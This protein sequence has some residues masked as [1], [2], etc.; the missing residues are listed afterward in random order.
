[1]SD[2][3]AI[4]ASAIK[5][6]RFAKDA[7]TPEAPKNP[8]PWKKLKALGSSKQP[9]AVDS[10]TD[11]DATDNEDNEII[12]GDD[13]EPPPEPEP[14]KAV[15]ITKPKG[16]PTDFEPSTL[17]FSK[18]PLMPK[19]SYA[20]TAT[21]KRLMKDLQAVQKV[22][23]STAPTDLGWFIDVEK[24][25]NVYQWIVELHSF[26]VFDIKGK[27][28]P[29]VA[30]M[31]KKGVKSIVLEMRFNKDYPFTP[32]YVRVIRPRF[33]SFNQ[34]GGGHIVL[35]GAMCMELLTN[36]GWSSVSSIESVLMQIR[37]AIASEPFA[38]LDMH[39]A[40]D[41]GTGEAA[42]G[43]MRACQTH[44]WQVP[45]GFREMAYGGGEAAGR[46]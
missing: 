23:D 20:T 1:V 25:D 35:G 11:S 33:L 24:L 9:I 18:L 32:P 37:M 10:D 26:H 46:F 22:Q 19:P 3:I 39:H 42:D 14:T 21:T 29:L 12:F 5:S 6:S 4:P 43:Y 41:Y 16:A 2:A 7:R 34:G 28:L 40:G 17:D 36:S 15:V 44:G 45:P 27:Q 31:K 38:R 8:A 30:D 13:P